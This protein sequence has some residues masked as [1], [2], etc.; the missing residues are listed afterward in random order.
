MIYVCTYIHTKWGNIRRTCK[1]LTERK[2]NRLTDYQYCSLPSLIRLS[3][4]MN[5]PWKYKLQLIPSCSGHILND[6]TWTHC[7]S[8]RFNTA[9]FIY[10]LLLIGL[11]FLTNKQEK[12]YLK[13]CCMP[14]HTVSRKSK[15]LGVW[16]W[17]WCLGAVRTYNWMSFEVFLFAILI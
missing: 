3:T 11:T 16:A 2:Y 5:V 12:T 10:T 9:W 8:G 15:T 7:A 13:P 4:K 6:F 1:F 14:L 17:I